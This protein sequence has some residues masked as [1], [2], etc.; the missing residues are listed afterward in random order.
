MAVNNILPNTA[1]PLLPHFAAIKVV[2][3][4]IQH[5]SSRKILCP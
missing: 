5:P 2:E 3:Q 4:K 1:F